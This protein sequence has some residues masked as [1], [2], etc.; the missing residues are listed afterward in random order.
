MNSRKR[1]M[2]RSP[3]CTDDRYQRGQGNPLTFRV[4]TMS[5]KK[6]ETLC[7]QLEIC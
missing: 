7:L 6:G 5:R 3:L 4:T 1:D 2:E